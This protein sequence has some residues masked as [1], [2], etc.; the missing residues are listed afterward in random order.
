MSERFARNSLFSTMAGLGTAL[1]SLFSMVLVARLLGTTGTGQ[2][3]YALW[4]VT[5]AVTFID[6]GIYQS[7]TRYLPALSAESG[8]ET[9]RALGAYLLRPAL[10]FAGFGALGFGYWAL[11]APEG[12]TVAP[13]TWGMIGLLFLLQLVASF[14]LG[15]LRGMQRF[16]LAAKLTLASLALQLLAVAAGA[17][18]GGVNGALLGYCAGQI[19][20]IA[21]L[22][23]IVRHPAVADKALR[24]RVMRF[25]LFAWAGALTLTLVWSRLEILFLEHYHGIET[26]ALFTAGFTFANIASQGPLLL[27]GALLPHFAESHARQSLEQLR[28]TYATATRVMA[29]LLFPTCFGLAAILPALLPLVYGQ[30][31]AG[32]LPA[33]EILVA[34]AAIGASGAVGSQMI[35]ARERSDFIFLSGLVGAVLS[36]AACFAVIPQFGLVGAAWARLAVHGFMVAYGSWF[37]WR[38]L[39]CPIPF[40]ALTKMLAAALLCAAAAR[41]L[42]VVIANPVLATAAAVAAGALVYVLAIRL[43][44]ALPLQD[45]ARLGSFAARLPAGIRP[46]VTG[47]LALLG[48]T[49]A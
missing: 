47:V 43:F 40:V 44:A 26:V 31:F 29:L 3:A 21:A 37:I 17:Q 7:L 10:A 36:V 49:R 30:A 28:S 41:L 9:A 32:A 23:R 18:L 12:R 46:S 38:R 19:L 2:I 22:G 39:D 45:I 4:I 11:T 8:D 15:A 14:G 42:I 6:F 16:D 27:T 48:P 25:A 5:L 1:G 24:R 33:G 13:T 35:Y 34:G 20:P